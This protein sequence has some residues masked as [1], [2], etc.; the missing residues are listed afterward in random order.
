MPFSN[1]SS[2]EVFKYN[3]CENCR[4]WEYNKHSETYG[5][6]LMDAFILWSYGAKGEHRKMIDFLC[7]GKQCLMFIPIG[8]KGQKR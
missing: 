1:G 4:H 3:I 2:Y 7:D 5:C 8:A 6:P